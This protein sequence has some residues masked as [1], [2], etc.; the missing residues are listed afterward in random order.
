MD[1]GL[2]EKISFEK[3]KSIPEIKSYLKQ[4]IDDFI[5]ND[6]NVE[7]KSKHNEPHDKSNSDIVNVPVSNAKN[8]QQYNTAEMISDNSRTYNIPS[9]KN[10]AQDLKSSRKLPIIPAN[11]PTN[12][13][14]WLNDLNIDLVLDIFQK[15]Y[16]SVNIVTLA[17]QAWFDIDGWNINFENTENLILILNLGNHWITITN[18]DTQTV[19]LSS[20]NRFNKNIFLYDSLY[21]FNNLNALKPILKK[22]FPT[23]DSYYVNKVHMP[24]KQQ[25]GN[26][27]G[28]FALAYALCLCERQEPS[29]IKFDQDTMRKY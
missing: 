2:I 19:N 23:R 5:L 11:E 20:Q 8:D 14:Y 21:D 13:D 22:M 7:N 25:S 17:Q 28:L 16:G 15:N 29:V 27:C 4:S 3:Y 10:K 6:Q 26:D 1:F 12:K 24:Y 9:I 18:I